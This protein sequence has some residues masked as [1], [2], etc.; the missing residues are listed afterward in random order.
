MKQANN[1]TNNNKKFWLVYLICNTEKY[2]AAYK[3]YPKLGTGRCNACPFN[4]RSHLTS[5]NDIVRGM[6]NLAGGYCFRSPL[7]K[8]FLE[9]KK[10]LI[11]KLNE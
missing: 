3:K 9:N 5:C 1:I 6:F 7:L 11:K 8:E 4:I 10:L 2:L